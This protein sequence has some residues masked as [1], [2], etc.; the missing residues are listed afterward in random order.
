MPTKTVN[1]V[2]FEDY[3]G[4]NFERLV[5]A[6]HLRDGWED[7]EWYGQTGS[8]MGRDIIGVQPLRG[9]KGRRTVIQCANRGTLTL[10]KCQRDMRRA[11]TVATDKAKGFKIVTRSKVSAEM[12]DAIRAAGKTLGFK[13]ITIW[14][15]VEF[16]EAL[17]TRAE[18]L[19]ER[20]VQA[21]EFPDTPKKLRK[22][23]D[24][25][26]GLSDKDKLDQMAAVLD[27]PA[28]HTPMHSESTIVDLR[29]AIEDTI[30]ALNT[31]RWRDRNGGLIRTIPS[32]HTFQNSKAR[33]A[34]GDLTLE[35]DA[36]RQTIARR[37]KDGSIQHCGCG[38]ADCT[39]F[40]MDHLV[41]QELDVARRT[42]LRSFDRIRA[43]V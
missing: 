38:K 15:G 35:V 13:V 1:R 10:A 9:K 43:L 39:V 24:D 19:L 27:R 20:F 32:R 12:R 11:S 18:T 23:V 41:E 6:Y 5:F 17:R 22:F 31:G 34:L 40:T 4:E 30:S 14:S 33:D 28:F 21:K 16:E 2:H 26:P 7:L 8:D 36:I 37:L 42:V 29:Q 25:H 3:G